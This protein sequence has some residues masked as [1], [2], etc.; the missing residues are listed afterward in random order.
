MHDWWA[1]WG[2]PAC[3]QSPRVPAMSLLR[4]CARMPGIRPAWLGLPLL[5]V[6]A[7]VLA[8]PQPA[9]AS[10]LSWLDEVVQEVV[11]EAKAG[12]RA[13]ARGEGT[14]ARAAGRLFVREADEGLEVVAR[15]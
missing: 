11:R 14:G 4:R 9:R 12:G 7:L 6:L 5:A 3:G 1:A 13:A 8:A 10:K 15:R 2:R